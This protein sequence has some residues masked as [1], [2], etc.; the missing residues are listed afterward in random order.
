MKKR[1]MGSL[2]A[3]AAILVLVLSACDPGKASVVTGRGR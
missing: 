3:G 2:V 1:R